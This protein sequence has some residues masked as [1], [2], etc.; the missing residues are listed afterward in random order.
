[1]TSARGLAFTIDTQCWLTLCTAAE[2]T[3][4]TWDCAS[5]AVDWI[6]WSLACRVVSEVHAQYVK[7]LRGLWDTYKD[8][9]ALDRKGTFKIVDLPPPESTK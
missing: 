9:Y 5:A 7:A 8:R 3:L 2:T 4:D 6:W 1:M